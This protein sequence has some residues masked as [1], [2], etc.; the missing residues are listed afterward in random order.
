MSCRGRQQQLS[1]SSTQPNIKN[2]TNMTRM[3]RRRKRNRVAGW[4]LAAV[5]GGSGWLAVA[6]RGFFLRTR[7]SSLVPMVFPHPLA[8]TF[9]LFFFASRRRIFECAPSLRHKFPTL[10]SWTLTQY[11]QRSGLRREFL[12]GRSNFYMT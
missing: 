6:E 3:Q 2:Q 5:A 4:W 9:S 12:S 8:R 10:E 1:E 7:C 11:L